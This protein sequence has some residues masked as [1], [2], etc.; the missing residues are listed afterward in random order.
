MVGPDR[1]L[2]KI[3]KLQSQRAGLGGNLDTKLHTGPEL[4]ALL[5][6]SQVTLE[7]NLNLIANLFP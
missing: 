5:H 6:V 3:N 7:H 2:E 1:F 4:P